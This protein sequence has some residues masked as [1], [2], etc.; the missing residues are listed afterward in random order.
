MYFRVIMEYSHQIISMI[1]LSQKFTVCIYF[2]FILF[3][4]LSLLFLITINFLSVLVTL[5]LYFS[6][7]GI[8]SE[9]YLFHCDLAFAN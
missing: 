3:M 4:L 1:K 7:C 5:Y 8:G 9:F 2:P 6:A